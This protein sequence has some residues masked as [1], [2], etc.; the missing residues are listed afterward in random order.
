MP[1]SLP[2]PNSFAL[3]NVTALLDDGFQDG[4]T[5]TVRDG[6]ITDLDD[7][8]ADSD[9]MI[10]G[11]GMM[12]MPGLV[13]LHGDGFERELAPRAGVHFPLDLA[14]ESNDANLIAS[15]ITTFFYSI[16][17]GF[18]PG[19]RSRKTVRDLL[20]GLDT[21]RPR[22]MSDSRIHIRHECVATQDHDELLSWIRS[23]RI[24]L[25]SLNDHLPFPGDERKTERYKA[26]AARRFTMSAEEFAAFYSSLL[27]RRPLGIEQGAELAEAAHAAGVAL[28]S[29]DEMTDEDAARAAELNVRICEFPLTADCAE[30][31]LARGATVVMGAPNLVRGGS[32]VGGTNVRDEI[33]AGRV[34]ALVS[35]YYYPSLLRAP[36]LVAELGLLPLDQAWSLVSG[37][38]AQAAGLGDR[39]GKI[40]V[41]AD[42]D[43]IAFRSPDGGTPKGFLGDVALVSARG[44][45]RAAIR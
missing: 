42:A 43:F 28:A 16:T 18:E 2:P 45:R 17:D 1:D 25:L 31:G 9:Q 44:K 39:K 41:G 20:D 19:I 4:V 35:D 3:Q 36:F 26:G 27:E 23:H 5:I 10:D 24:D 38:P 34:T 32:H 6:R 12:V 13:D 22:L 8:P 11:T 37:N 14:I 40:A 21:L 33:A 30:K 15:G 29:H 7:G